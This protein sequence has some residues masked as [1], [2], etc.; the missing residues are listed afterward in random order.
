MPWR[1]GGYRRE[2]SEP[3]FPWGCSGFSWLLTN[4]HCHRPLQ[5]DFPI[6]LM[7][8]RCSTKGSFKEDLGVETHHR[9]PVHPKFCVFCFPKAIC[10][11]RMLK[12]GLRPGHLPHSL[13]DVQETQGVLVFQAFSLQSPRWSTGNLTPRWMPLGKD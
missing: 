13:L 11:A 9:P 12:R 4:T 2:R 10:L 3:F 8:Q 6:A 7:L 5:S 1:V